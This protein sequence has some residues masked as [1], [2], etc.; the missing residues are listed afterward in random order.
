MPTQLKDVHHHA[1]A[2]KRRPVHLGVESVRSPLRPHHI[3]ELSGHTGVVIHCFNP[4]LRFYRLGNRLKADTAFASNRTR[5]GQH[6]LPQAKW[7]RGSVQSPQWHGSSVDAVCRP[8]L[9]ACGKDKSIA[10]QNGQC[11]IG[12]DVL[13]IRGPMALDMSVLRIDLPEGCEP[14]RLGRFDCQVFHA[15]M[16][17][18]CIVIWHV[19]TETRA[20]QVRAHAHNKARTKIGDGPNIHLLPH[21]APLERLRK[22][23]NQLLPDNP[24]GDRFRLL[25]LDIVVSCVEEPNPRLRHIVITR[26]INDRPRKS[27]RI[28]R[29][30]WLCRVYESIFERVFAFLLPVSRSR[31]PIGRSA[32]TP[33]TGHART[34]CQKRRRSE[35]SIRS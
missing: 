17:C 20:T 16:A 32:Q 35:G 31:C 24:S 23:F 11:L 30:V 21:D 13:R 18:E 10:L 9:L 29:C 1:V 3:C 19:S 34:M 28:S 6:C 4:L 5:S 12:G 22:S 8:A 15:G 25:S 27:C 2:S 26:S 7:K 33:G 14:C